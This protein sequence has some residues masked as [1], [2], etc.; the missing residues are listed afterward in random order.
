MVGT[1][2]VC[3]APLLADASRCEKCGTPVETAGRSTARLLDGLDE[4]S[5]S[6]D[7]AVA[8]G[9]AKSE[10]EILGELEALHRDLAKGELRH[11]DLR[12]FVNRVE[13]SGTI[14]S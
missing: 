9:R 5:R 4:L 7:H 8:T 10:N 3:G 11:A 1:C 6:A 13:S 12:D 2:G 14:V